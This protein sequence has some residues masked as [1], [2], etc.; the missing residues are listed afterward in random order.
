MINENIKVIIKSMINVKITNPWLKYR[1]KKNLDIFNFTNQEDNIYRNKKYFINENNSNI[2]YWFILEDL[3]KKSETVNLKN[4]NLFFLLSETSYSPDYYT[5]KSKKTFLKQFKN[6]YTP[7]YIFMKNVTST[8]PFL[9]WFLKKD[10]FIR[11]SDIS[12]IESFNS[13]SPKK[14]KLISVICSDKEMTEFQIARKHFSHE[15]KKHFGDKLD[16]FTNFDP[17][18]KE[19]RIAPYKYHIVLENQNRYNSFSEKLFDSFIS[20]CFTIFGGNA[21][22]E[23]YFD[24]NSFIKININDFNGSIKKIEDVIKNNMYEKNLNSINNSKNIVLNEFNLINRIDKIIDN[25]E[26]NNQEGNYEKIT[27]YNKR[28]FENTGNV[29]KLAFKVDSTLKKISNKLE[30]Y[31]I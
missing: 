4:N 8:P 3:N 30:N 17:M 21:N 13:F 20:S 11:N 25:Y 5:K 9:P 1:S 24:G 23:D 15:L 26:A 16:L 29:A 27:I 28:H 7:N 14:E 10:H 31:Y 6:I 12:E 18:K 19:E 2:D 22:I